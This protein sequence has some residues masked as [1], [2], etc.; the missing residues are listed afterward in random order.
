MANGR[1]AETKIVVQSAEQIRGQFL[2][3][4]KAQTN[5]PAGGIVSNTPEIQQVLSKFKEGRVQNLITFFF[6]NKKMLNDFIH[7][8]QSIISEQLQNLVVCL[9][10]ILD[11][12]SKRLLW[13]ICIKKHFKKNDRDNDAYEI[14]L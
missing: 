12:D 9:P 11:F 6:K 14:D 8:N 1:N 3:K 4:E 7:A 13:R 10:E 5:K 2:D